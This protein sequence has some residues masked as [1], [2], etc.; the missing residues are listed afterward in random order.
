MLST[1]FHRAMSSEPNPTLK[2]VLKPDRV[3]PYVP[4][5]PPKVK[6]VPKGYVARSIA[7]T[8]TSAGTSQPASS[9]TVRPAKAAAPATTARPASTARAA[10]TAHAHPAPTARP[11]PLDRPK[12]ALLAPPPLLPIV[13]LPNSISP[14]AQVPVPLNQPQVLIN[15]NLFSQR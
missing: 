15:P 9:A 4:L 1:G 5:S 2:I 7:T 12:T 8:S 10:T 14:V 6:E 13:R 11:V 3:P